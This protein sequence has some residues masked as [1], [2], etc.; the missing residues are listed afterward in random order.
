MAGLSPTEGE[1]ILL[2]II[3]GGASTNEMSIP[4]II[5]VSSEILLAP[6]RP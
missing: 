4:V 2:T 5:H 1:I 6:L 3:A